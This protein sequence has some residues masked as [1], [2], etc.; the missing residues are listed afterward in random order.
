MR[1][2][3]RF[4]AGICRFLSF[5]GG[6]AVVLMMLHVTLDVVLL[7]L[8]RISMNSTPE[9]VARYYMVAVAFLPL[10]WLTL[11]NQMI[12]VELLDFVLPKWV[13]GGLDLLVALTGAVLYGLLTYATWLKALREMRSGSYVELVSFQLPIWQSHFLVPAGFGLAALACALMTLA[14]L[15]PASREMLAT[16]NDDDTE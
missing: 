6:A 11:R 5:V 9:I 14:L 12:S 16:D 4:S 13:R 1:M 8:F 3:I 7:N 15:S 2:M 10:G